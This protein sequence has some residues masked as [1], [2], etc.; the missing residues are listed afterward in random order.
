M[1]MDLTE[2][3]KSVPSKVKKVLA[4]ISAGGYVP[5]LVGGVVRDFFLSSEVGS[6]WDIEISHPRLPWD[7]PHW[8][9]FGRSLSSFGRIT[10]L[11]YEIIRL[12]ID[13]HEIELSPPRKE[14]FSQENHHK[15]F[16]ADYDLSLPFEEAIL[17]RD[18]TVNAMGLRFHSDS[19]W[20]FL[21]PTG[22]LLHLREKILHPVSEDFSKDPVRFLRAIRFK[23]KLGFE[24]SGKLQAELSR[25]KASG[26]SHSYFWSEM[27]KSHH[28]IK[29]LKEMLSLKNTHP[30][31][32]VPLSKEDLPKLEGIDKVME[33]SSKQ[34]SWMVALEWMGISSESWV[35]YF[36]LGHESSK[37]IARW[38]QFSKDFTQ[39][40]PEDFHRDFEVVAGEKEFLELFDWYFTTKQIMQKHPQVNLLK[41]IE[42]FLPEWIHLF[43]FEPVK[44]VKHIDPPLRAK[45]QVWNLCQRL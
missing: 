14:N 34:E 1:G 11:P 18:F 3:E 38:A 36:H 27:Q 44:D 42:D 5:T 28:P 43:R 25:M 16:T 8:K 22:G 45:Y 32:S 31:L 19:T 9:D 2:F 21:D 6:D 39:R 23:F 20:E 15:N 13:G 10:F 12:E 30:E 35:E 26:F 17:R 29:F 33:D 41:M 24:L 40:H 4:A 7:L 37:R